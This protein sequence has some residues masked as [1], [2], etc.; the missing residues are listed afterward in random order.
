MKFRIRRMVQWVKENRELWRDVDALLQKAV[1]EGLYSASSLHSRGD[2]RFELLKYIR[3]AREED[4]E[5]Q[6]NGRP[7]L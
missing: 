4:G 2:Y 1:N 7:G 6:E 5:G 3:R